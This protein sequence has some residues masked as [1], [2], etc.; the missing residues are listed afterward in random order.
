MGPNPR[1][2]GSGGPAG[3]EPL[4][5]DGRGLPDLL[6]DES[7]RAAHVDHRP[8]QGAGLRRAAGG[9]LIMAA[10]SGQQGPS[11]APPGAVVGAAVLALAVAIA[12]VAVPA[13][14]SR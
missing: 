1:H 12:V 8:Q 10:L 13:R 6:R 4:R 3:E 14:P 9:E 2:G 7:R 11:P 5:R